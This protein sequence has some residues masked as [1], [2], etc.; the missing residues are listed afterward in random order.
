MLQSSEK[1]IV[2]RESPSRK[3]DKERMKHFQKKAKYD[4]AGEEDEEGE[5]NEGGEEDTI[6]RNLNEMTR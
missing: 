5:G 6:D 1:K 2:M 3:I 4:Y